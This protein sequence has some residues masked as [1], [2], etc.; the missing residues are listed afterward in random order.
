MGAIGVAAVVVAAVFVEAV[1]M[2]GVVVGAETVVAAVGLIPCANVH[3]C[4]DYREKS[5]I[6][7]SH[8]PSNTP[9]ST[10]VQCRQQN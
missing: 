9:V 6:M 8:A 7:D 2:S 4:P 5:S 1:V 3:S 10:A